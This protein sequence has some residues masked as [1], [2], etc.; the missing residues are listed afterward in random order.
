[1]LYPSE[2]FFELWRL[3][4]SERCQ[5]YPIYNNSNNNN[6]LF[7]QIYSKKQLN[8]ILNIVFEQKYTLQYPTFS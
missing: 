4:V 3:N 2:I 5:L 6:D 8:Y 7:M 1:M